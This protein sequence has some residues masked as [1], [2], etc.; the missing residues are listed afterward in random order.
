MSKNAAS[1]SSNN[2]YTKSPVTFVVVWIG[3]PL[4]LIVTLNLLMRHFGW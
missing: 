3:A 1:S 2:P 4:V